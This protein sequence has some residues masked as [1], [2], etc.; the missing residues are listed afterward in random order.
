MLLGVFV[1]GASSRMGRP[2]GWLR[3][4][5]GRALVERTIALAHEAGLAPVLVGRHA[6]Y[7]GMAIEQLPDALEGRGPLGGLASLL[8]R[9]GDGHAIAVAVDMPYLDGEALRRLVEAPPGPPVIAPRRGGRW[10]P[11]IAR[12]HAPACLPEVRARLD[13]DARRLQALLEAL[14]AVEIDLDPRVLEDW[15]TPEDLTRGHE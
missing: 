1:G 15:D 13:R 9:A 12:Y 6:A 8:E 4:P 7:A 3:G 14:G 11:L 5:D 10:E 2:K